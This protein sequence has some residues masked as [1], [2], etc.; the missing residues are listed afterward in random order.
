MIYYFPITRMSFHSAAF[1]Y[2]LACTK[3]ALFPCMKYQDPRQDSE[4]TS[5][6][7]HRHSFKILLFLGS[8]ISA[9]RSAL[10]SSLPGIQGARNPHPP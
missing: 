1:N 8:C 10:A 5:G 9:K 6:T 7:M 4:E 3:A 2:A